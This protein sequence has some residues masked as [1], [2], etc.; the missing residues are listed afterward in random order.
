MSSPITAK[1][2]IKSNLNA[3]NQSVRKDTLHKAA[4]A[5][6]EVV[7]NYA[8][9]NIRST[10]SAK[11]KGVRGLA[12]SMNIRVASESDKECTLDIGP[13]K[14]YGRIQELGGIIK[15]VYAKMLSWINDSGERVFA[16]SVRIPP[17]PY[18]RPAMDEHKDDIVQAVRYQIDI[19]IRSSAPDINPSKL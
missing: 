15:P 14:V 9:L 12:G 8:K 18:L 4:W 1:V 3:I 6:A 16:R 19:A 10:F 11:S 5:G 7:R 17:R 2:V 13:S